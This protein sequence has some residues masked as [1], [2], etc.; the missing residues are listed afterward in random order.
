MIFD[1]IRKHE[2]IARIE[3]WA[4]TTFFVFNLFFF[5]VGNADSTSAMDQAPH[6]DDFRKANIPYSHYKNFFIPILC[7]QITV[8]AGFL[9]LNFIIVPGL[10]KKK[11]VLINLLFILLSYIV[12]GGIVGFSK[13]YIKGFLYADGAWEDVTLKIIV[14]T[15]KDVV[16]IFLVF[17]AYTTIKYAGVY[18]LSKIDIIHKRLPFITRESIVCIVLWLIALL[19]LWI[20]GADYQFTVGWMVVIPCAIAFYS[21]AFYRLIPKILTKKHALI[22]FLLRSS[23]MIALLFFPIALL[24]WLLFLHIPDRVST[25]FNLS[26]FN[27]MFQ[28][29][30]TVP[31]SWMLY[32]FQQNGNEAVTVLQKEL[33]QSTAN[34]DFLRSQINP[35]FLF[36]ALNTL[37]GTA[38]QENAD[39]TSEGIQKLGDM[40]RFMLQENMQEKIALSRDI[41]YLENYINLQ[42]LRTDSSPMI[43]IETNINTTRNPC[44]IAPM[45]LIPFVENAFKHGISFRE[46]SYINVS[47]E[48]KEKTLYFDVHNSKHDRSHTDPE[49]DKS[50]IGLEN[51]QQRLKLLYPGR[52]ELRIR[53]SAKEFFVH[54]AIQLE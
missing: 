16:N 6:I 38:L 12:I 15:Y 51:V 2:N 20:A 35:H 11:A 48:V 33:E 31:V 22:R 1:Y 21:F 14:D 52:H 37:Y 39:R 29:F 40:M 23:L 49:K 4:L 17:A 53:E 3:F 5:I 34:I 54:L 24:F 10:V 19:V 32:R 46:P 45:L 36:N 27:T 28:L 13:T 26:A 42:R 8:F 43:K 25:A 18:L 7:Q 9:Y 47:L 44:T 30:I 50:G 41:D